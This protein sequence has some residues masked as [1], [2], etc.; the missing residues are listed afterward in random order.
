MKI[1]ATV[2]SAAGHKTIKV[3]KDGTLVPSFVILLC[4]GLLVK[5]GILFLGGREKQEEIAI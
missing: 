4:L 2:C 3:E 1:L 5:H